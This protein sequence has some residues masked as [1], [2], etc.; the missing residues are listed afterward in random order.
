MCS[1]QPGCTLTYALLQPGCSLTYALSG[2]AVQTDEAGCACM[3]TRYSPD[4]A[5]VLTRLPVCWHSGCDMSLHSTTK[6]FDGHNMTGA[7]H[8]P[9]SMS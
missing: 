2:A 3:C 8:M 6:Y 1:R 5:S 7:V 9:H 4:N